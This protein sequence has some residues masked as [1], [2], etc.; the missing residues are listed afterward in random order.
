[1]LGSRVFAKLISGF[2]HES[3]NVLY[4]ELLLSDTV[5][6]WDSIN[7]DIIP[8]RVKTSN[9][10]YKNRLNDKK[11]QYDIEFDYAFNTINNV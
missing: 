7:K 4:K 5:Y 11:V 8:I 3:E 1:M 2:I 6:L 10:T 9:L